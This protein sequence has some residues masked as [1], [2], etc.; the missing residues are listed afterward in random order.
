MIHG[1]FGDLA[2][3]SKSFLVIFEVLSVRKSL[4]LIENLRPI[5]L[6]PEVRTSFFFHK[7]TAL[8]ILFKYDRLNTNGF[9]LFLKKTARKFDRKRGGMFRLISTVLF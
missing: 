7:K 2:K 6:L 9:Q 4:F 3:F 8:E 5:P 1:T